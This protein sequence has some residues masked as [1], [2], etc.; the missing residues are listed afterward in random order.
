MAFVASIFTTLIPPNRA[1]TALRKISRVDALTGHLREAA[2][3]EF[4]AEI[5][6]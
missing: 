2:W 1:V 6:N 5:G 3:V 4:D